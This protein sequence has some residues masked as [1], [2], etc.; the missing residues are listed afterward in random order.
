MIEV[1]SLN[2]SQRQAV[3]WQDGALLVLA[4]PG[5]GK[6]RVLTMRVSRLLGTTPDKHFKVLGL[7]FTTKAAAEMRERVEEYVPDQRNRASLTTFHSFAAEVLRQHGSSVGLRPNFTILTQDADRIAVLGDALRKLRREGLDLDRDPKDLLPLVDYRFAQGYDSTDGGLERL[8]DWFRPL[9]DEYVAQLM[10]SGRADFATLLWLCHRLFVERPGVAK[11]LR[12]IYSYICVDEFQDTNL[13]Q[14]KLLQAL[15]GPP[16]SNLFVVADDDQI[17]YQ[18]NGASPERL[19]SLGTYYSMQMVQLPENYRCPPDVISLA[20]ALIANNRT[21]SPG[22]LPLVAKRP[23]NGQSYKLVRCATDQDEVRWIATAIKKRQLK[24]SSCVV[25]ARTNKLVEAAAQAI[26]ESGL[27]AHVSKRKSEFVS[28]PFRWL[29][30]L[31]RLANARHEGE[32]LRRLCKS[33]FD[34]T[35]EVVR[36]E[37]IEPTAALVGGDFLRAWME[38]PH[39]S[40]LEPILTPLKRRLVDRVEFLQFIE[41]AMPW[42]QHLHKTLRGDGGQGEGF[43]DFEEEEATWQEVQSRIIGKIGRE[44]VSLHQFL[45]EMD[46]EPKAPAPSP[47]AVQC[48]TAHSS[49]GL[50]FD[51]VFLMGMAEDQLPSFQAKKRGDQS[52]EM[53]EERRNCFVA[54]TRV[55]STLTLSFAQSYGGRSKGPSRFLGEMGFNLDNWQPLGDS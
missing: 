8:P 46:L 4:G 12:L 40:S 15:V 23:P 29:H 30:A 50:E 11:Q 14:Y 19:H 18:W 13:A 53:E 39:A 16:P 51:H 1:A 6:T 10:N 43:A 36:P 20:N 7:T 35:Q 45:Q 33:W 25:L 22:K 2:E 49:K 54:I 26:R 5:S 31:L 44:E 42:L 24:P 9:F 21:R 17:I 48:M 32:Q 27:E 41:Q 34:L 28:A 3:E 47:N 52:A 37:D 55:R 38:A